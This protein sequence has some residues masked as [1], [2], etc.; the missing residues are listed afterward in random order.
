MGQQGWGKRS[1]TSA[2]TQKTSANQ[3]I[4][5]RL[6]MTNAHVIED[7]PRFARDTIWTSPGSPG[8]HQDHMEPNMGTWDSHRD[9]PQT[10]DLVTRGP[11][12]FQICCLFYQSLCGFAAKR[13]DLGSLCS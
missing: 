12:I 13:S 10:M 4:D 7:V 1:P 2:N 6:L 9:S 3:V 11:F 5:G 8:H